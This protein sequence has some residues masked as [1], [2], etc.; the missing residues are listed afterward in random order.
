MMAAL[1][2]IGT[3]LGGYVSSLL[4]LIVNEVS[5]ASDSKWVTDNLNEGHLDYFFLLIAGK[6]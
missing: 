4:M 1:N 5:K 3:A 2:L 6:E